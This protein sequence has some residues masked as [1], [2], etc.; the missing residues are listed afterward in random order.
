M[1]IPPSSLSSVPAET[2]DSHVSELG[3]PAYEEI[4]PVR[5]VPSVPVRTLATAEWNEVPSADGQ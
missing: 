4:Q 3:R 2:D 5:W 1:V